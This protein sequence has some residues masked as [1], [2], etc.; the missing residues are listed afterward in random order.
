MHLGPKE[1]E[2]WDDYGEYLE[3]VHQYSERWQQRHICIELSYHRN[4]GLPIGDYLAALVL[5][6]SNDSIAQ[7]KI[8]TLNS[9]F[10][11]NKLLDENR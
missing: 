7:N 9:Y 3:L 1:P 5:A 8:S 11:S 6:L 4:R 10:S 2:Y